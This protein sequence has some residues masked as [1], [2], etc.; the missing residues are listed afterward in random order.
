MQKLLSL[1]FGFYLVAFFFQVGGS[2]T[3]RTV[4]R[5]IDGDTIEL[6]KSETVRLIGIDAP[7]LNDGVESD[8]AL[9]KECHAF[10]RGLIEYKKVRLEHDQKTTDVF[11]RTLAYIYLEDGTFVN[12]KVLQ[13]GYGRAYAAYPFKYLEEFQN[14]EQVAKSKALGIWLTKSSSSAVEYKPSNVTAANPAQKPSSDSQI[15]YVTK[16]G[17]KYHRAGCRS[18]R[19]SAI[20]MSL[21][22]AAARYSPC[23]VCNPPSP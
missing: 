17:S 12:A 13:E 1:I 6:D 23:S 20:P 5:I 3:W 11:N 15:V 19:K 2:Q 4:T 7:E 16:T 21:K 18:L 9:A 8:V 22:D 14:H 10:L